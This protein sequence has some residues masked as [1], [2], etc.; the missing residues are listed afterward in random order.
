MADILRPE[1]AGHE[2]CEFRLE[3]RLPFM[4]L[5][6]SSLDTSNNLSAFLTSETSNT[7]GPDMGNRGILKFRIC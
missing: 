6:L 7:S 5:S 1:L 4:F 3:G 2:S